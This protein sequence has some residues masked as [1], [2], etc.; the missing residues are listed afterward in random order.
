MKLVCS[1]LASVGTINALGLEGDGLSELSGGAGVGGSDLDRLHLD[2]HLVV[3]ARGLATSVLLVGA[4][5]LASTVVEDS[6]HRGAAGLVH[7][8]RRGVGAEEG[9]CHGSCDASLHHLA[10]ASLHGHHGGEGGGAEAR[11]RT[12]AVRII[13]AKMNL[14]LSANL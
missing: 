6:D 4:T 3:L 7:A 5:T 8:G 12:A 1:S 14:K 11:A 10:A 2:E 13:V 9:R